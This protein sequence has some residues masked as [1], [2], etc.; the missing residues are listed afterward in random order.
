MSLRLRKGLAIGCAILATL[1]CVTAL[2]THI[3]AGSFTTQYAISLK[4]QHRV[5]RNPS[6][7]PSGTVDV[8]AADVE[9]LCLLNGVGSVR[10]AAIVAEREANGRYHYP[11]DLLAVKGIGA[12]ILAKIRSQ[13]FFPPYE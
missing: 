1:I 8:N 6:L 5:L 7:W 3:K 12:S 11:E 10:A 4:P 2:Y 9:T 13:L